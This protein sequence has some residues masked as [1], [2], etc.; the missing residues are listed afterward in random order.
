MPLNYRSHQRVLEPRG[1]GS[2][3]PVVA[4]EGHGQ[5]KVGAA[6]QRW[7]GVLKKGLTACPPSTPSPICPSAHQPT[8]HLP[9]PSHS[10]LLE[11]GRMMK[12]V[13]HLPPPGSY[14]PAYSVNASVNIVNSQ[15][16]LLITSGGQRAMLI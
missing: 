3:Q 14:L 8:V 7:G 12:G 15:K 9:A 1:Q 11:A 2:E 6:Y 10:S 5:F 16:P 13:Q 4:E